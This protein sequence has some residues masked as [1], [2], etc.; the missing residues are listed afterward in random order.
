[1]VQKLKSYKHVLVGLTT[2]SCPS[3]P[4]PLGD[5]HQKHQ[6]IFIKSE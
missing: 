4:L 6:Y 3:V 2:I 1:M 5:S